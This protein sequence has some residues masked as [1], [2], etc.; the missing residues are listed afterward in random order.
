ME[1][2]DLEDALRRLCAEG[3]L[4]APDDVIHRDDGS[5]VALW[6]EPKVAVIVEPD[7]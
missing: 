3:D 4:P 5:I 6:R 2:D 7:A 1:T